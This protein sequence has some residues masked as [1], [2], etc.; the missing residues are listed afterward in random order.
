LHAG[1]L[2][3]NL[4]SLRVLEKCGFAVV[5]EDDGGLVVLRLG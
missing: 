5:D 3:A 2:P 1:V 4:G